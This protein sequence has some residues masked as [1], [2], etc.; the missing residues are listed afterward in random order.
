MQPTYVELG[1]IK[2]N[3]ITDK[4]LVLMDEETFNY[5]ENT[6]MSVMAYT[7][8]A[9]DISLNCYKQGFIRQNIIQI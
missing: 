7:S 6:N 2:E 8:A 9:K 1:D 3:A 4:T 5:H